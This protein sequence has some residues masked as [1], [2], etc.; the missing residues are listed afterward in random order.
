MKRS[1]NK[2]AIIQMREAAYKIVLSDLRLKRVALAA[3]LKRIDV[4][5]ERAQPRLK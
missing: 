1:F 4:K 2:S 3:A 5:I